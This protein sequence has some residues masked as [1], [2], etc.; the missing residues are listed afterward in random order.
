MQPWQK[1]LIIYLSMFSNELKII[2]I[3]K[4]V[5]ENSL[6]TSITMKRWFRLCLTGNV[7]DKKTISPFCYHKEMRVVSKFCSIIFFKHCAI[8]NFLWSGSAIMASSKSSCAALK[9]CPNTH[10]SNVRAHGLQHSFWNIARE[11]GPCCPWDTHPWAP[12]GQD[13]FTSTVVESG[14]AR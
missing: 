9:I 2:P 12:S 13:G 11:T 10:L 8:E 3:Q 4:P 1:A 5:E 7:T 14:T 6:Y